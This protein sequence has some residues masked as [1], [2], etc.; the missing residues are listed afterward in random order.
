MPRGRVGGS[1]AALIT[2]AQAAGVKISPYQIERWRRQG[3]LPRAIRKGLGRGQGTYTEQP[4]DATVQMVIL[5]GRQSRQGSPRAGGHIIERFA[6]GQPVAEDQIRAAFMTQLNGIARV[7]AADMHDD[8]GWQ[9]RQDAAAR[10]ARNPH[11]LA[12]ATWQE[13]VDAVDGREPAEPPNATRRR[14]ALAGIIHAVGAGDEAI[15]EE[16]AEMFAVA[17][18]LSEEQ[19]EHL[20]QVQ[21]E[22]ELRGEDIWSPLTRAISVDNLRSC[23]RTVP[24]AD[25]QRATSTVYMISL[26]Q[27]VVTL[28]GL[29][30]LAGEPVD[31]PAPINRFNGQMIRRMQADPMWSSTIGGSITLRHRNR[32]RGLVLSA[33]GLLQ[34]PELLEQAEQ[35]KDRLLDLT[36][37]GSPHPHLDHHQPQKPPA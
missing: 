19:L 18:V 36:G 3:A 9:A 37:W 11:A 16:L 22:A 31:L 4:D 6:I 33:L 25:L 10:A 1:T 24:V 26:V 17:G 28:V 13:L 15:G 2:A 5:L 20:Q 32:I 21:R 12:R 30:D 23:V 35:Y 27:T 7:T 14:A 29:P 34:V 8:A